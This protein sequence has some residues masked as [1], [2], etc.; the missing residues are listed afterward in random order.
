MIDIYFEGKGE[1]GDEIAK[2]I[3]FDDQKKTPHATIISKR[4]SELRRKNPSPIT[5]QVEK[6]HRDNLEA[7]RK[8]VGKANDDFVDVDKATPDQME[9]VLDE[10]DVFLGSEGIS[11]MYP[12]II[13]KGN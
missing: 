5:Y 10:L 8:W 13:I 9:N 7:R 1:V 3:Q 12:I 2:K 6:D 4:L 11:M